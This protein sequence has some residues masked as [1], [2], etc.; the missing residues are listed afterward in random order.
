MG[1]GGGGAWPPPPL[2]PWGYRSEVAVRLGAVDATGR[3]SRAPAGSGRIRS[4]TVKEKLLEL[5]P[6][7]SDEQTEAAIDAA[8]RLE[9]KSGAQKRWGEL[10]ARAAA[11][12]AR[13]SEP[14]D[15]VALVR[16]GREELERRSAR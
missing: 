9:R 8:Q 3:L 2:R 7:W 5:V 16:E 11:L 12:R 4:V 6:R 15:V 13:Q 14:V 10:S 1:L